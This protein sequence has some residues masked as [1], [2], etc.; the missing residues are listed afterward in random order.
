MNRQFTCLRCDKLNSIVINY[1][2]DVIAGI[3]CKNCGDFLP[4]SSR[5]HLQLPDFSN[6]PFII[7]DE[8]QKDMLQELV[9]EAE[10]EDFFQN[11]REKVKKC[12]WI[13]LTPQ[14]AQ[15]FNC[16]SMVMF[17]PDKNTKQ[18]ELNGLTIDVTIIS[19]PSR[20]QGLRLVADSMQRFY[21][22]HRFCH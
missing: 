18:K 20:K 15:C 14:A 1:D 4:N 9:N 8:I 3:D 16:D 17:L 6:A 10:L 21:Q 7:T 11:L 5:L 13:V 12:P 19:K 22:T 2:G